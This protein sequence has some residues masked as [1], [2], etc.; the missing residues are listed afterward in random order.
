[1]IPAALLDDEGDRGFQLT[2]SVEWAL[3]ANHVMTEDGDELAPKPKSSG[4]DDPCVCRRDRDDPTVMTCIDLSCVLFACQ[5]ECRSSCEAGDQCG[6]KRIQRRQWKDLE[7][8]DAGKK[9][10]GLRILEECARGDFIAEYVGRAIPKHCLPTLFHRYANERRLYIMALDNNIYLDARRRGG[11][12]RY[13]NHSCEPNCVVERWKVRGILRAAVIATKDLEAGT[14]L[15]FDYQ[16]ERKRGRAPTKC[17]CGAPTCR[18]TLEVPRSMEEEALERQLSSHWTKPLILRARNEIVNRCVRVF[19][20]ETQEYFIADVVAFDDTTG[21]H[22]LMYR[23]DMEEVWEDLKKEDWMILDEEAQAYSIRKKGPRSSD[24]SGGRGPGG[25]TNESSSLLENSMIASSNMPGMNLL[26]SGQKAKNY[27]FVQ[28][29]IKE[30]MISKHLID[31]CQRSCQVTISPQQFAK[32][33]LTPDPNDPEEQEKYKAL[34]KST[35][36]TVWKLTIVGIDILK[37]HNI[38][39]KNVAYLEKQ[40]GVAGG[41]NN[42]S[43]ALNLM[44][45]MIDLANTDANGAGGAGGMIVNTTGLPLTEV[46]LPRSIVDSA[47]RRLPLLREMCR[48][49]NITF[50]PSESKSKQFAKLILEG[51]LQSDIDSAKDHLWRQLLVACEENNTPKTPSGVYVD[52]GFLGGELSSSDF[53]R[54]LQYDKTTVT[55]TSSAA[56]NMAHTAPHSGGGASGGG[57]SSQPLRRHTAKEDLARWSPFFA[58]FESTQRCT[59][60]VQSD[61][62]KGRIDA[63]NRIVSEATPNAPRKIYFGCDPKSIPKLWALVKQRAAEVARGVKYLYLGPDRL[64][65]PMMMR[66]SGQFFEFVRSV[67]GASVTVDSMTGDHLRIDGK[68]ATTR[69]TLAGGATLLIPPIET[70]E[71]PDSVSEGERA[72]LA[73]ELIR[74]QI[75]LFR[76]HCVRQQAWIFG[77]DWTLARRSTSQSSAATTDESSDNNNNSR[78]LSSSTLTSSRALTV[79]SKSTTNACLE[80]AEIISAL[81]LAGEVAAHATIIFY[82]F[83]TLL[84]HNDAAESNLKMREIELACIFLANKAQKL[85]KWKKLDSVL[86]AAYK[87]FYPGVTFD[88]AKEEVLVWEEKVITAES[89]ILETLNHDI[90]WRGFDWIVSAAKEAGKIDPKL[91]KEA[92]TF[93]VSGPVL[94]A[95]PDLWLTYGAEYVYAAAAGF[96]DAKLEALFPALSLIPFKVHQAAEIILASMRNT[97]FGKVP[98]SHPLFQEGKKGLA[99]RLP[100]IKET[101][102]SSMSTFVPGYSLDQMSEKEQRYQL[103]GQRNKSRRILRGA[104]ASTIKDAVLPALDGIGAESNCSIFLEQ[105]EHTGM[106]QIVLE[107]SWRAISIASYLIQ[108]AVEGRCQ[109]MPVENGKAANISH[110]SIQAK[111]QPGLLSMTKIETVDGWSETIQSQLSTQAFWGRKTGGKS[112]V[113]GKI[114]ESDLR[115]GGLRWWIPPRYGPSPSGTICDM[116]LVNNSESGKLEALASLTHAFQGES[117]VF[118]MLTSMMGKKRPSE[119]ATDRFVPVSLQ[120]WPTEKVAKR[121]LGK[122]TK[123]DEKGKPKKGKRTWQSGFSAGALQEMQVLSRIHGLIKSPQGHPNFLLPIAVGLPSETKEI[124]ERMDLSPL[125]SK[126]LDM[127]LKRIDEDIFSLTRTSLEN[128]VAAEKERKRKDMVTGPHLVFHPTPFVLQRFTA[129]KKKRDGEP[130]DQL[131]TPTIFASWTHDLLSAMLHCHSNDVVLRNFLADQIMVDHSGV[132][133]FGSFYRATVLSK[134]DKRLDI[135]RAAKE[136][137]KEN[138]KSKR[139]DDDDILSNPYAAPE[140][141]LGSPKF[142]KETDIWTLGCLL[143]HLLLGKPLYTGKERQ[144][145]LLALY[146]LVGIPSSENFKDGVK[147]PYFEKPKKKYGPGVAKALTHMM[148]EDDPDKYASAFD[149]ISRMLHLDPKKRISAKQALQHEY[150]QNFFE[151]STSK[152]FQDEYVRDW[153]TL[154]KRLMRSSKTEEDEQKERE[155]GIKRK[156]MLLAASKDTGT[157]GDDDLYDMDDILGSGESAAKMPKL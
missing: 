9:G 115:H 97:S 118:S 67:T 70:S 106:D 45:G 152:T 46:V 157:G 81:D 89:E 133:K 55:T 26:L 132:V 107:G 60:W 116:F 14:E 122:D 41:A 65:Q 63:S 155:R 8:F 62:D 59:I 110:S 143:C 91:A 146:K 40:L 142:T 117:A 36:G 127:N 69:T 1:M 121:E 154:K 101:C 144:S 77:R 64:Y 50:I 66:N 103:L 10:R 104:D 87:S 54:L 131:I 126:G 139:D 75:E 145:M 94:A 98:S 135:L 74:L 136:R 3:D 33:P 56:S 141:L 51:S 151:N 71:V 109:L 148:K 95:G 99:K 79:D 90:F 85:T 21:K 39:E 84:S 19:S 6:N 105:E 61:A 93:S 23:H 119:G 111:G 68:G 114:K 48:S 76:D 120:R 30:A 47:K 27:I 13:I 49:V 72:A 83:T 15:S 35:D 138:R 92:L 12:A 31:R 88:S 147:F 102:A 52:L 7:V 129:R 2:D 140:M 11:I 156:A 96:L 38:L 20:K 17:H 113:P 78:A 134:E 57:S 128:E 153:I 82:R 112:C 16:W 124:N 149:L 24:P 137:K 28:T 80:I 37:A 130:E 44:G 53:H 5:E 73:E 34:D 25:P 123:K 43:G 18:G 150:M 86:E 29:P 100:Y 125:G 42:S 108:Q 58:S 32:P 4:Y 22:L